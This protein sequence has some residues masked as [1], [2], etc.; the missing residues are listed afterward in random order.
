MSEI[1]KQIDDV[2]RI[3]LP[4]EIRA[5][6]EIGPKDWIKLTLKGKEINM[7]KLVDSCVFCG[8]GEALIKF[9]EKFVCKQC[10]KD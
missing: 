9:G 3:V 1:T 5:A 10:R 6:L 4:K 8:G 2:G 7:K